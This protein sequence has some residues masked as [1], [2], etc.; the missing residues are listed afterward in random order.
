MLLRP[1]DKSPVH[2]HP[3]ERDVFLG[4]LTTGSE[5]IQETRDKT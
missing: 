1:L 4:L 2:E 3:P 5:T